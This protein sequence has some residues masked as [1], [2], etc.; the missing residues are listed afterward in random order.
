[1][2][3]MDRISVNN[4][5]RHENVHSRIAESDSSFLSRM[6]VSLLVVQ[7][8]SDQASNHCKILTAQN[9]KEVKFTYLERCQTVVAS[10]LIS[11]DQWGLFKQENLPSELKSIQSPAAFLKFFNNVIYS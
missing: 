2:S 7:S 1:M 8:R 9:G 6:A 10:I 11:K 5:S 3:I 4:Q